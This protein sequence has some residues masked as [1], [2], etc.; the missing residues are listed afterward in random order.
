MGSY[1]SFILCSFFSN[2]LFITNFIKIRTL[3][4]QKTAFIKVDFRKFIYQGTLAKDTGRHVTGTF[5]WS[6]F[7]SRVGGTFSLQIV[8]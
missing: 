4:L 3:D 7:P 8:P 1:F 2:F 5:S 6:L